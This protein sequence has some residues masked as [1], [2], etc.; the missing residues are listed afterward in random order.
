MEEKTFAVDTGVTRES[1]RALAAARLSH[2][3]RE[4]IVVLVGL[5]LAAGI[6]YAIRSPKADTLILI[7]LLAALY[8]LL[9]V[10]LTGMRLY[11]SRN[12]AVD[13]IWIAFEPD[14]FRVSTKVEESWFEYDQITRMEENS[15]YV[16]LFLRHHTPLTFRKDQLAVGNAGALKAFL[17]EKTGRAFR[18]FRG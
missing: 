9:A 6:L 18:N 10:P 1:C 8:A 13:S 16:I 4:I 2:H 14:A 17:E 15:K 7:L 12:A 5:A 11:N 3:V